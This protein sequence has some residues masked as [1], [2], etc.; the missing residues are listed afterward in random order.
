VAGEP[1][2][3]VGDLG[4]VAVGART[5]IVLIQA[6]ESAGEPLAQPESQQRLAGISQPGVSE[7][8]RVLE[9]RIG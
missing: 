5:P 8:I 7:A 6:D 2:D 4:R 9:S 3:G 1:G